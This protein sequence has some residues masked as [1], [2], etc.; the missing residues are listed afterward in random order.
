MLRFPHF[1]DSQLTDGGE[2]VNLMHQ[3]LFTP[4]EDSC[5][6]F[7]WRLSWPQGHSVAGRI[8][9]VE[10]SNDLIG[11][12]THDLPACSTV[13]QPAMLLHALYFWLCQHDI[14]SGHSCTFLNTDLRVLPLCRPV[15][16]YMFNCTMYWAALMYNSISIEASVGLHGRLSVKPWHH[17][18]QEEWIEEVRK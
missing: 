6:H 18:V 10:K 3:P 5:T 1:L 4:Q 2:V 16:Q 17:R 8:R 9:S 11:T 14:N 12:R 7:C 15:H 13:P